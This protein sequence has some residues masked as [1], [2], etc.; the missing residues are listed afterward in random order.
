MSE[1]SFPTLSFESLAP[2]SETVDIE[3][4]DYT[5]FEASADASVQYRDGLARRVKVSQGKAAGLDGYADLEIPLVS[6]CL[7]D[8]DGKQ[9][10]VTDLKKWPAK[11][12]K[13]LFQRIKDVSQLDEKDPKESA[14]NE[15]GGGQDT[16]A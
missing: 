12:I 6:A 1:Q 15:Q 5:L 8:P 16:S 13:A 9:V 14:K 11:I 4:K 3:K 7:R 10:S 2:Y